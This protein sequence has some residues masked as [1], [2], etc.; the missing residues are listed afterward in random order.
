MSKNY[1]G[2]LGCGSKRV[3]NSCFCGCSLRVG[4]ILS[5][6]FMFFYDALWAAFFKLL[7]GINSTAVAVCLGLFSF[8]AAISVLTLFGAIFSNT[9]VVKTSYILLC[10]RNIF[11]TCLLLSAVAIGIVAVIFFAANTDYSA[12]I[13]VIVV[14]LV[15][16]IY[17]CQTLVFY[18][19]SYIVFSFH[20]ALL[21]GDTEL[22][23]D[24]N[25]GSSLKNKNEIPL[26]VDRN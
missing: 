15:C 16:L 22:P 13:M 10:I 5:A 19:L 17:L 9:I 11:F 18:Y 21:K 4:T 12:I 7:L 2:F 6:I 24:V 20:V 8:Q 25:E 14:G 26:N 3:A 1:N 23:L